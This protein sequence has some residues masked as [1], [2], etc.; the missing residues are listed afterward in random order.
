[1][2]I[3]LCFLAFTSNAENFSFRLNNVTVKEAME[4][5]KKNT[6]YSFVF[7]SGELDAGKVVSVSFNNEPID[8]IVRQVLAGQNVN[9][10]IS[11]KTIVLSSSSE[12]ESRQTE[13]Y[14]TV[15]GTVN[16][17]NGQPIV[18]AAA[19]IHGT[20]NGTTTN[21]DGYYSLKVPSDAVLDFTSLGFNTASIPVNG[22]TTINVVLRQTSE[23]LNG[24][25]VTAMGIT[26]NTRTLSYSVQSIKQNDITVARSTTGNVL[27]D[28]KGNIAG[29]DVTTV[30]TVGGASRIVLRGVK[31]LSG[32]ANAMIIVDGVEVNISETENPTFE[33][34]H[35]M[36]TSNA[37]DINPDD[38]LSIDVLKGPSAAA[39]YGSN[40]AN[41]AIVITTKSGREGHFEANYNGSFT[42]NA[43]MYLMEMQNS[44]GRGNGGQ[45]SDG[46]GESWG[47]KASCNSDNYKI[48]FNTGYTINNS[49]SVQG[50]TEKVQNYASYT[51][52]HMSGLVDHNWMNKHTVNIRVKTEPV[53]NLSTDFKVTINSVRMN[54]DVYAGLS[55]VGVDSYIMTRDLSDAEVHDYY[56]W[57][58][59]NQ[60]KT[61]K[62]WTSSSTFDNPLWLINGRGNVN[63]QN[64]VW[65]LGSV[66]Y[67]IFPWLSVQGRYSY[68]YNSTHTFS[69]V[70]DSNYNTNSG[71][72]FTSADGANGVQRAD[73]LINGENTFLKDFKVTYNIGASY[74]HYHN[75]SSGVNANGLSKPNSF[76]INF[77]TNP[78]PLNSWS[79]GEDQAVYGTAQI[80]WRDAIY[81]DFSAREDWTDQL[82]SP[83][84]YFY[85]SAGI[86]G[87]L[88][89]LI[90]MPSWI[91][92]G[93]LRFSWAR[94]G[95]TSGGI[96]PVYYET[97]STHGWVL[98]SSHKE[99][100]DPHPEMTTSWE[101]GT[102][103][104][105][106]NDR[107]GFDFCYYDNRTRNQ[108]IG[109]DLPWSSGYS[110]ENIECGQIN[111]NGFELSIF[112]EPIRTND[113]QWSTRFN[114]SHNYNKLAKLYQTETEY[115][116]GGSSNYAQVWNVVGK[117]MGEL[118]GKTWK[119]NDDGK[120]VVDDNGLPV[121]TDFNT[122][123]GNYNPKALFGWSNTINYKRLSLNF[124]INGRI[125][126]DI[127]SV[128]DGYL[129]AYGVGKYTTKHREGGWVL[130]AVTEDG[131][132]NTTAIDAEQFWR[133]VSSGFYS[134]AGFFLYDA[135]FVSL[136]KLS[137]GYDVPIGDSSFI[138]K[139]KIYLTGNNLF[140]FYRGRSKMDIPGLKDRKA[141][142]D[143]DQ[144]GASN[145]YQGVET[146]YLPS[147]RSFGINVNITF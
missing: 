119:K 55:G 36:P 121:I 67:N 76:Q 112:A 79:R 61:R 32:S 142:F 80:G 113:W 25:V 131:Q 141:P 104:R 103:W 129:S 26:R 73:V 78:I 101:I 95:A 130:D 40:A 68:D 12:K 19:I 124:L 29:A 46:A 20:N 13:S 65:L 7:I 22:R 6:G 27:D 2:A 77:A 60:I 69:W 145:G 47:A 4:A 125:G 107:L 3:V 114:I 30:S 102:E 53:K 111:N 21:M 128:T 38:I 105:F 109:I 136:R 64:R 51:N 133:H 87:I 120:Y 135:S 48:P 5:V 63:R 59:A 115:R 85:P 45:H 118:R 122:K 93:K 23:E 62:Y 49:F 44:F 56:V 52:S 71:G 96:D 33:G 1:M 91:S 35:A 83:Y 58:E 8:F 70:G 88:S 140:F 66:K 116:I 110:T 34:T 42:M 82:Y 146:C 127:V 18:G 89:E 15:K 74:H 54:N 86:T 147:T 138:K 137:I 92:F 117:Q 37:V 10:E 144:A 90:K 9:Y 50:G 123:I 143:P 84:C 106:L 28:L 57:D 126:G 31:D 43:P 108:R 17:E 134:T 11:G 132:K 100:K 139:L 98:I 16:D 41:G 24:V 72:A 97:E 75:N 14:I 81:V 94:V 99:L 39:L